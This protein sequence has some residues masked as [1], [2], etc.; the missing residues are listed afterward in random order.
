MAHK[1]VASDLTPH[2]LGELLNTYATPGTL[3]SWRFSSTKCLLIADVVLLARGTLICWH[4]FGGPFCAS[5]GNACWKIFGPF[6]YSDV[7]PERRDVLPV[8]PNAKLE[9]SKRGLRVSLR[10]W[11]P[12]ALKTAQKRREIFIRFHMERGIASNSCKMS[13]R[14]TGNTLRARAALR[15]FYRSLLIRCHNITVPFIIS[16]N[17]LLRFLPY[18][19]GA[20]G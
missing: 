7:R 20:A 9:R 12:F 16:S 14:W 18:V 3:L 1:R 19:P 11:F 6:T 17:H 5:F 13:Y 8:S 10:K 4:S 2:F 15:D